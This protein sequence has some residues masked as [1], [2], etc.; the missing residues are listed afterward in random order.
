M[1]RPGQLKKLIMVVLALAFL[2]TSILPVYGDELDNL[3]KQQRETDR[4]IRAYKNLISAKKRELRSLAAQLQDLEENIAAT[5]KDLDE[6][7]NQLV[8]AQ[9]KVAAAEQNLQEAEAALEE[10]NRIFANRLVEIYKNGD[11]NF[12][13]V[14]LSSTD[15]TDFLVRFELL[16]KI[17]EQDMEMLKSIEAEKERIAAYKKELEE[18]RDEI[19]ALK[20]RTEEKQASLEERKQE[21]EKLQA[22]ISNEKE[23]AERALAE[24][25]QA[26]REIAKK[27]REIQARLNS[28]KKSTK[29]MG[30]KFAWPT[31]GYDRITSDYGYRI[32][33]I[34]KTKRMHTGVDIAAPS[35]AEVVAA[36]KGTVVFVG[37]FGAYGK[38]VLVEHGSNITTMYPHL[39]AYSVKEGD[40]VARGDQIGKVGST[41]LS[42]GPHLHFEVRVNG[43]P[44]NPWNYLR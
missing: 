13:E 41:G 9:G 31:P 7:Q 26:S 17:A 34:L 19:K 42:T 21:K 12:M 3:R 43:E 22:Q 1:K 10:R 28:N 36:E 11:V 32:H 16:S 38:T 40:T 39:S 6:L 8:A 2:G 18:R 5:E 20:S 24:E 4:E 29:Y 35:G 23:A 25:E 33:P 44:V 30:G 37:W 27:I 15:L 14:L